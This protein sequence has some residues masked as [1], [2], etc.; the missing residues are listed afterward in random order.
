MVK[1]SLPRDAHVLRSPFSVLRFSFFGLL[2][3]VPVLNAQEAPG[4]VTGFSDVVLAA[5]QRVNVAPLFRIPPVAGGQVTAVA[6]DG[7]LSIRWSGEIGEATLMVIPPATSRGGGRPVFLDPDPGE[8]GKWRYRA[9]SSEVPFAGPAKDSLL[10]PGDRFLASPL[11]RIIDVAG[12]PAVDGIVASAEKDAADV[13][14]AGTTSVWAR[15]YGGTVGWTDAGGNDVG[16]QAIDASNSLLI[17][18]RSANASGSRT[19]SFTGLVGREERVFRA[20]PG[21]VYAPAWRLDGTQ[22]PVNTA[23]AS[24]GFW[25]GVPATGFAGGT[26]TTADLV[27][28]WS[29]ATRVWDDYYYKSTA[30]VA[31]MRIVN[32]AGVPVTVASV[33]V[34]GLEG[35]QLRRPSGSS[36]LVATMKPVQLAAVLANTAVPAMIIDLDRDRIADGWEE[37]YGGPLDPALDPDLDG[38]SNYQEYLL[39]G[40]PNLFDQPAVPSTEIR[41]NS[42]GVRELWIRFQTTQGCRYRLEGRAGTDSGTSWKVLAAE[43]RGDGGRAAFRDTSYVAPLASRPGVVR[44]YRVVG[45]TPLDTD[46][47]LLSDW[48]E[49]NVYR[50]DVANLDTD[51]DGANDRDETLDPTKDPLTFA[52]YGKAVTITLDPASDAQVGPPGDWLRQAIGVTVMRGS[53]PL[54]NAPVT[55]VLTNGTGMFSALPGDPKGGQPI[56][57]VPTDAKGIARAFLRLGDQ[58]DPDDTAVIQGRIA[59][60]IADVPDAT[61]AKTPIDQFYSAT[62]VAY[63]AKRSALPDT[64]PSNRAGGGEPVPF[65]PFLHLRPDHG[66]VLD[67]SGAIQRWQGAAGRMAAVGEN[68]EAQ[69]QLDISGGRAWVRFTGAERLDLGSLFPGSPDGLDGYRVFFVAAPTGV[70][71]VPPTTPEPNPAAGASGQQYLFSSEMGGEAIEWKQP[72]LPGTFP[73]L[74]TVRYS[75]WTAKFSAS[76]T[77]R[78][79]SMPALPAGLPPYMSSSARPSERIDDTLGYRISPAGPHQSRGIQAIKEDILG[80]VPLANWDCEIYPNGSFETA[81][82]RE[83]FFMVRIVKWRGTPGRVP[84]GRPDFG[85]VPV[86][87]RVAGFGLSVGSKTMQSFV[88]REGWY[89]SASLSYTFPTTTV[90]VSRGFSGSVVSLMMSSPAP[91]VTVNGVQLPAAER[92]R[93][94]GLRLRYIG[95]WPG[96]GNGYEGGVGDI[97]IFY[98]TANVLQVVEDYLAAAYA[99]TGKTAIVQAA[100]FLPRWWLRAL[101]PAE[102][103]LPPQLSTGGYIGT[104]DSDGDKLTNLEEFNNGTHPYRRDTDGDGLDDWKEVKSATKSNPRSWDSDTDLFSDAT[105]ASINLDANGRLDTGRNGVADGI[106]MIL[107]S[108]N[109]TGPAAGLTDGDRNGV[110]DL[111]QVANGQT[112]AEK[113]VA[114][115]DQTPNTAHVGPGVLRFK[116]HSIGTVD[117]SY[118]PPFVGSG[119]DE[120]TVSDLETRKLKEGEGW[121]L[122]EGGPGEHDG[123]WKL[124]KSTNPG[125]GT[126][127]KANDYVI[128]RSWMPQGPHEVVETAQ[129]VIDRYDPAKGAEDPL[130]PAEVVAR[131][132]WPD[133]DT[134]PALE[135]GFTAWGHGGRRIGGSIYPKIVWSQHWVERTHPEN[136]AP[137]APQEDERITALLVAKR[138]RDWKGNPTE[139]FFGTVTFI[140]GKDQPAGAKV[141]STKIEFGDSN[142]VELAQFAQESKESPGTLLLNPGVTEEYMEVSLVPSILAVDADRDGTIAL[143]QDVTSKGRPYVFWLNNDADGSDVQTAEEIP[144]FSKDWE[145]GSIRSIRDLEDVTRLHL[146]VD[147]FKNELGLNELSLGLEWKDVSGTG[148]SIRLYPHKDATGSLDYLSDEEIAVKQVAALSNPLGT[149]SEVNVGR[150]HHI[151]SLT[152]ARNSSFQDTGLIPLL[153]EGCREG[154]GRLT[155]NLYNSSDQIIG[156]V[157]SVWIEL[158]DVRRM[159]TRQR[160]LPKPHFPPARTQD[161]NPYFDIIVQNTSMDDLAYDEPDD[162]TEDTIVLTHGIH[163]LQLVSQDQADRIYVTHMASTTF[164]RLWWQGFRGRFAFYK[165]EALPA[166]MY[167]EG[168]FR[169]WKSGRGLALMFNGLK[170]TN[171]HLI[172]HS[173]GAVVASSAIRDYH[174]NPKTVLFLNAAIPS[175]CFDQEQPSTRPSLSVCPDLAADWGYR[176]YHSKV[177]GRH[178]VNFANT[179]DPATGDPWNL[180]QDSKPFPRFKY[181]PERPTIPRHEMGH[182]D[183]LEEFATV[184]WVRERY[185]IDTHESLSM[186]CNGKVPSLGMISEKAGII[187]VAIDTAKLP[188]NGGFGFKAQHGAMFDFPI[189][190][191]VDEFFRRVLDE[192]GIEP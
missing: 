82:S 87:D 108:N 124:R 150:P 54:R 98:P 64:V 28:L 115:V 92:H 29:P 120:I 37:L 125:D 137:S 148:P 162:V 21:N 159:Y 17:F 90:P 38:L 31:W 186:M 95:G 14:T 138:G 63:A 102:L 18:S 191:N 135:G 189:Q 172:S 53:I 41:T 112:S 51:G 75:V 77:Q 142:P 117:P 187:N 144:A 73:Y 140:V 81:T 88:L 1:K 180:F 96:T 50:T 127:A 3:A 136:D 67:S 4:P 26:Q 36:D 58:V 33:K 122:V 39:G 22:I 126:P 139:Q 119:E 86:L 107:A 78:R 44:F 104:A 7:G 192:C 188:G 42:T 176:G 114:P 116:G 34:G 147:P 184:D 132:D 52:Y 151:P 158:K 10:L 182:S 174:A 118:V 190:W 60:K 152:H 183:L 9:H 109:T 166:V 70:R 143:D 154:K 62:F 130:P 57:T 129:Q 27:S 2:L 8:A 11:P 94:T 65:Q 171:K 72:D 170:G 12:N 155:L 145:D 79:Y 69:P 71:T 164:K 101:L 157:G 111:A 97:L 173:L 93:F 23:L 61:K 141:R 32:G 85:A 153:F 123:P 89:P 76:D 49:L 24:G 91:D 56:L 110:A 100:K 149:P 6:E 113:P 185:V 74:G 106:D 103:P 146:R 84:V 178:V 25:T 13:F 43:V 134:P 15:R 40:N 20:A 181:F 59:A 45:L 161:M 80:Q 46:R 169:A 55:F 47:D 156:E 128:R 133:L 99:P 165:W 35:F 68:P 83:E 121:S 163:S 5:G 160:G 48:E 105:D 168:E 179:T 175:S 177:D 16:H 66:L 167:N 19:L 131:F 30:P